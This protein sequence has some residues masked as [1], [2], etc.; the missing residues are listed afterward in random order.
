LRQSKKKKKVN[1]KDKKK[2]ETILETPRGSEE[3]KENLLEEDAALR[4]D[5]NLKNKSTQ[6]CKLVDGL[7]DEQ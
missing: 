1:K 2:N 3:A 5:M 4:M 7:I 6:R